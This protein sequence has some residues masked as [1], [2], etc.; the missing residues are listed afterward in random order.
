[1]VG[2]E[3]SCSHLIFLRINRTHL[4]KK[5]TQR[6]ACQGRFESTRKSI[7]RTESKC[8]QNHH[9][10]PWV[11]FCCWLPVNHFRYKVKAKHFY[12][13][14]DVYERLT[15]FRGRVDTRNCFRLVILHCRTTHSFSHGRP[16]GVQRNWNVRTNEQWIACIKVTW[17]NHY[18]S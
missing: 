10:Y 17:A 16:S 14:C 11:K 18:F 1:M 15:S 3:S 6:Y 9:K 5:F 8:F 7:T 13:S 4:S 12:R 2:V